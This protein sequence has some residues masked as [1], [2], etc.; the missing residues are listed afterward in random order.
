MENQKCVVLT[1]LINE[2]ILG[3]DIAMSNVEIMQECETFEKLSEIA[4]GRRLSNSAFVH[5]KEFRLVK[6]CVNYY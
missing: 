3:F 5:C 4:D 2:Q 6:S 1:E